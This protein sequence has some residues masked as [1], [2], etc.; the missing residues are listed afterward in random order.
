MLSG[1]MRDYD[2]AEWLMSESVKI[3]EWGAKKWAKVHF[4]DKG[5]IFRP[6]FMV[7]LKSMR[8]EAYMQ[9]RNVYTSHRT[10]SL[11]PGLPCSHVGYG[12]T[13]RWLSKVQP[14]RVL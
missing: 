5:V 13:T 6:S 4:D 14:R 9:V 7:G 2:K 11:T 3:C 8:L 12:D 1:A 10:L